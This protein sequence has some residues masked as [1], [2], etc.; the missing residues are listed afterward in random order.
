MTRNGDATI[1]DAV[2]EALTPIP[3]LMDANGKPQTAGA[4]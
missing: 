2:Q 1:G 4:L 3:R